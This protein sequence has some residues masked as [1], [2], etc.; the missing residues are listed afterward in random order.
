MHKHSVRGIS[1]ERTIYITHTLQK[2][3]S[4]HDSPESAFRPKH[5]V[6]ILTYKLL[7]NYAG[8]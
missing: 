5:V 3:H 1:S 4:R 8:K 7:Q 2:L 6:F